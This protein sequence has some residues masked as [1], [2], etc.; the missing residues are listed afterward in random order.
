MK[1]QDFMLSLDEMNVVVET[2]SNKVSEKFNFFQCG[3]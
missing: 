3:L 1:R 2:I